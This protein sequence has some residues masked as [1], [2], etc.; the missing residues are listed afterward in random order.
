MKFSTSP[1]SS[2]LQVQLIF[3]AFLS[4]RRLSA[5]ELM[6]ALHLSS[7]LLPVPQVHGRNKSTRCQVSR[8]LTSISLTLG[9]LVSRLHQLH[10]RSP[11]YQPLIAPSTVNNFPTPL[12]SPL[13]W[14]LRRCGKTTTWLLQL[15]LYSIFSLRLSISVAGKSRERTCTRS[16]A[17]PTGHC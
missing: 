5:S 7:L 15:D 1:S 3:T 17:E 10:T 4:H 16:E 14:E 9:K 13:L 8:R 12:S 11:K 2:W 6:K